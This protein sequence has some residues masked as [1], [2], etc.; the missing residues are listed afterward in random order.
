[1]NKLMNYLEDKLTEF[2]IAGKTPS[3]VGLREDIHRA[4]TEEMKKYP[5]YEN[6]IGSL[7]FEFFGTPVVGMG[8]PCMP[9]DGVYIHQRE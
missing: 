1:M 4:L 9:S 8:G 7:V 5:A 6:V 2:R 3:Y